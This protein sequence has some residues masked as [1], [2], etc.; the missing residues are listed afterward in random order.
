MVW[1]VVGRTAHRR[2]QTRV[3][4]APWGR[5]SMEWGLTERAGFR[6]CTPWNRPKDTT[7]VILMRMWS[8]GVRC[9]RA[10]GESALPGSKIR[11][12]VRD[13]SLGPCRRVSEAAHRSSLV[14][15][16][17]QEMRALFKAQARAWVSLALE[18]ELG[19]SLGFSGCAGRGPPEG[20]ARERRAGERCV[21]R[22]NVSHALCRAD[23]AEAGQAG[24]GFRSQ[25]ACSK[26]S[27]CLLLGCHRCLFYR[28]WCST[29]V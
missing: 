28:R 21:S 2:S 29:S 4:V 22:H 17:P 3:T 25:P 5:G 15:T 10:H 12:R 18:A 16:H 11:H 27:G 7:C 23:T 26:A 9:E 24:E 20:V 6:A 14:D 13:T 8:W 19:L 1:C